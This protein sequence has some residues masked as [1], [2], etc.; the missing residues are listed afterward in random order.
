MTFLKFNVKNPNNYACELMMKY[1]LDKF[2]SITQL[3]ALERDKVEWR[4]DLL[5]G[6]AQFYLH[7]LDSQY[8]DSEIISVEVKE[9]T[10]YF[11]TSAKENFVTSDGLT[12]EVRR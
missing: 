5:S 6:I 7:P 4:T 9:E 11:L 10:F 8:Y 2:V 12:F 3:E 1:D